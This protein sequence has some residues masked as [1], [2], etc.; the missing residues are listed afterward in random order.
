MTWGDVWKL[1][2]LIVGGAFLLGLVIWLL[3]KWTVWEYMRSS[4]DERK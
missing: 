3:V 2:V 4:G 1:L